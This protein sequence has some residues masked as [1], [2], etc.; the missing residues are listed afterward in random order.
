M[1]PKESSHTSDQ[2]PTYESQ[3]R[4]ISSLQENLSSIQNYQGLSFLL[5]TFPGLADLFPQQGVFYMDR[6]VG[7]YC[8][9]FDGPVA[10]YLHV[11]QG[12]LSSNPGCYVDNFFIK[13]SLGA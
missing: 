11:M 6:F 2:N 8:Y 5:V 12:G 9:S 4:N 10:K 7:T 1:I 3:K 13:T